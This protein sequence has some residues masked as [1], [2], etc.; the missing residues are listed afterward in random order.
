VASKHLYEATINGEKV[1][2]GDT[3]ALHLGERNIIIGTVNHFYAGDH[4]TVPEFVPYCVCFQKTGVVSL[5]SVENVIVNPEFPDCLPRVL[6][7]S[8]SQWSALK[9]YQ[10]ESNGE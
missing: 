9:D 6:D 2:E 8:P 7:G 4:A 5:G 3:V 10:E 1:S